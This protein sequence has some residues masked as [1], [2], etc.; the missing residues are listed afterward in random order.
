MNETSKC[1][2]RCLKYIADRLQSLSK[3]IG[4]PAVLDRPPTYCN[5]LHTINIS[6]PSPPPPPPPRNSMLFLQSST[7]ENEYVY[8]YMYSMR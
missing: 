8:M 2:F 1:S 3:I 7:F 4:T 5:S 6:P